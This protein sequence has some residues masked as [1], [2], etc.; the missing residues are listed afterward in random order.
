MVLISQSVH[1]KS[2]DFANQRKVV[3]LRD[4]HNMPFSAIRLQVRN[5]QKRHPSMD[6]VCKIYRDFNRTKG[7][8]KYQ[9]DKCGRKAWKVDAHLRA[10]VVKRLLALR[11]KCT[12]TASTLQREVA[13]T[14]RKQ[15][16]TS[17]VRKILLKAG[18]E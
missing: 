18:Y 17:T 9:Y 7:V 4:V 15:V 11:L 1:P 10:F 5:L 14:L 8:R 3:I 13:K 16:C 2:M 6:Q 12:C